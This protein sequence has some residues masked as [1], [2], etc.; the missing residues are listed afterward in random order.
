[1]FVV[2]FVIVVAVVNVYD[3]AAVMFYV[4]DVLLH[5]L[6]VVLTGVGICFRFERYY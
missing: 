2:T 5:S 6:V 4:R 3:A 1:M